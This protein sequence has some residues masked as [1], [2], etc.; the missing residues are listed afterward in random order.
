MNLFKRIL[1]CAL[2]LLTVF[3]AF[4]VTA[5]AGTDS[6]KT[7]INAVPADDRND[8]V[9]DKHTGSVV[10]SE[11]KDITTVT[12][13]ELDFGSE[14]I[15]TRAQWLHDLAVIFEM[16][17]ETF[18]APDNYFCDLT[19]DHEYYTDIILAVSYGAVDIE[20]GYELYPDEPLTRDFAV[21]TL[22][23][24]LGYTLDEGV[25][26]TFTDFEA[27]SDPVSAQ[28]AVDRGW[29]DC[30]EGTFCPTVAV[31]DAEA[32]DMLADTK[33]VLAKT[34]IDENYNST[35]EFAEDVK[36]IPDGTL[37]TEDG[38][39]TVTV[40][41]YSVDITEGDSF[42]VFFNS[43]PV[44]YT[45]LSVE[46]VDNITVIET[47]Q[48]ES[49]EVFNAVD[50]QGVIYDMEFI[51]YEGVNMNVEEEDNGLARSNGSKT[52]KNINLDGTFEVL[53]GIEISVEVV[54]TDPT[55]SYRLD[56]GYGYVAL[57]A[58]TEITYGLTC[59]LLPEKINDTIN[60]VAVNI[61]GVGSFEI[62]VEISV[63][64][65]INGSVDGILTVGL[66]YTQNEG[67][68]A[69]KDFYQQGSTCTAEVSGSIGIKALIGVT[70]LPF[71]QAYLYA[72]IGFKA[73]V[74]VS[75]Y[76]F[77]DVVDKCVSFSGYLYGEYGGYASIKAGKWSVTFNP[78]VKFYHAGNSPVRI[79]HHYEFDEKVP[80]CT[81]GMSGGGRRDYVTGGTS[82]YAG[83][84]WN[85]C[86]GAYTVIDGL[87]VPAYEY[88][89]DSNGNVTI[90]KFKYD[91]FTVSLPKT[92]NGQTVVSVG[93]NA[94]KAKG[95]TNL[96]IPDTVTKIENGAF[97]SCASI[98]RL[99]IPNSVTHIYSNAFENCTSLKEINI[100]ASVKEID[101]RA[102]AN[103]SIKKLEIPKTL[104]KCGANGNDS[105]FADCQQLKEITFEWGTERIPQNLFA[106][107]DWLEEITMPD[108]VITIS[109]H[110]FNGCKNLKRV[111][112]SESLTTIEP[113]AFLNCTSLEYITLP[114]SLNEIQREAFKGCSA[115]TKI[116]LP[117]NV[118]VIG[119][120][121]FADCENVT[122]LKLPSNL[123]QLNDETFAGMAITEIEIPK[124]LDK[125]SSSYSWGPFKDCNYLKK[126]SFEEG[127]VAIAE[128]LFA[129]CSGLEEITIPDTVTT[130]ETSAFQNCINLKKVNIPES[131]T[132]IQPYAFQKCS[133]LTS[134]DLPDGTTEIQRETFRECTALE[135]V[136]IPDSVTNI[137]YMAFY[138]CTGLSSIDLP[139]SLTYLGESAFY[140]TALSAIEIPK[141]LS[142]TGG[143]VFN[144][145][146]A[147]K[148]VTFEKGTTK[149][150]YK[151]LQ[152]CTGI[153]EI[154][155][156]DT[157]TA[158]DSLAFADCNNLKKVVIPDSVTDIRADA[159]KNC[160][161]LTIEG[162]S[163]SYAQTF[164]QENGI[165]F[166]D[167]SPVHI[168][169]VDNYT[170]TL[171]GIE[172]IKE[173]RFALGTYET[174]SEIKSAEQNV[175][176]DAST[177]AK[178][179]VDTFMTYDLPWV[180]TY[181]FWVRYNDGS[182]YFLYTDVTE[183]DPYVT[184]Y[185]VKLTVN[186]FG[187]NYKD[188]WL[189][190][191]TF[192]SYS[193]IKNS[194][195]FKY[196]ASANKLANYAKTT[197]D[198]TYTMEDPGEYTVLIRY[199]DGTFDV[200]HHTLTVTTPVLVENGLQAIITNIPDI[201]IIRTAYGHY[202]SVADIKNASTVRYFNNK[203]AIKD[204][205]QY[206]IQYREEGEVT[207]IVEYNDGYKHF[208]YYNVAKKV[209]TYTLEGNVITFGNLD[210]LYIIRYAP[211]KYTT[212]GNIKKA[213]GVQYR[214]LDSANENGEIVI[215]G[216]TAGRW[217]FMV[218]YN[219]DSYNFYVL[220]IK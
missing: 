12:N 11:R 130:I 91:Y 42:A 72:K 23:A 59:D 164:A 16:S 156:P 29:V 46:V 4:P 126:V 182:Q 64:G 200:I 129:G 88:R 175:T 92:I 34:V 194:T 101:P 206:M 190:K 48:A 76:E 128:K 155:I 133:S 98:K 108:T 139:E 210:D 36:V 28:I 154:V 142:N 97:Q 83:N 136:H 117:D 67:V 163:G 168:I 152:K 5:F 137:A 54:M 212:A 201:K 7:K 124:S 57:V 3:T 20:A 113:F 167:V 144:R 138:G 102:F 106:K 111:E 17:M 207:I 127:T 177:V 220:D 199:N 6:V 66:E 145:C 178:Y 14:G 196:Q 115:L 148:K 43:I 204:A 62:S 214:K 19:E 170:V 179:T 68:R 162:N 80:K 110:V 114:D 9:G 87:M 47:Q 203:T 107:C 74:S 118:T 147:L 187:E 100:P 140:E 15:L 56:E 159:F 75:K 31:T 71:V 69:V 135:T 185:G 131:V 121:A 146:S 1:S 82:A 119:Q 208:F 109:N 63:E 35:Y 32:A 151:L 10:P 181:T 25:E 116:L 44:V 192:N 141:A 21:S 120:Q 99:N 94:F 26:Y 51:P 73:T 216:L 39:G 95:M 18:A 166:V 205:E 219:D 123:I 217:S 61:G 186:D 188:V 55:V 160:P 183:I 176:L 165:T 2:I 104:E 209:P 184:S 132:Q 38:D 195:E 215:D 134:V 58:E 27:C 41:D 60:L 197:H 180:G 65:T 122:S 81:R 52:I 78:N 150:A 172:D 103:T 49:A 45:A 193:E 77:E 211:G 96:S 93:S 70:K 50:A 153:E 143:S 191:G 189:A 158:I 89:V 174:G 8:V 149:V 24:C 161:D 105:P 125:V 30:V 37:V 86:N 22:N 157:V 40:T 90:T 85:G 202:E 33:S 218:Q 53:D 79:N 198:F 213:P 84:G 112:F 13:D 173:I 169:S 171:D